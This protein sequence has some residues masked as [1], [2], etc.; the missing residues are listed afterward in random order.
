MQKKD[1]DVFHQKKPFIAIYQNK[2]DTEAE[3]SEEKG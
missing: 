2:T 1:T 3:Y